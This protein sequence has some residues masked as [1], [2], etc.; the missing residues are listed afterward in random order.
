MALV[1]SEVNRTPCPA[2]Q[3]P[4]PNADGRGRFWVARTDRDEGSDVPDPKPSWH[5]RNKG[6]R[7][8]LSLLS[9]MQW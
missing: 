2:A 6:L 9:E 4:G 8:P 1:G 7:K 3:P 5:V